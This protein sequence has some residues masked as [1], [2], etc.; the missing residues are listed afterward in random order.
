MFNSH[1]IRTIL[2]SRSLLQLGIWIRNF[3]ILL[4]ITEVTHND[5]LAVSLIS[6]AEFGPIF[7][8]AII[9]GTFADR[10]KPKL[11][12]IA[13]DLLSACSVFIVLLVLIYGTWHA[14]FY[15]TLVSSIMS[16]FSQP[17]G[18]KLF[19]QHIPEDKLQGT[20]A[21]YQTVMSLFMVIGPLIGVFAFEQYGIR[22]SLLAAGILFVG[23]A[24]ILFFLPQDEGSAEFKPSRNF[25]KE[26]AEGFRYVY[27][28][29]HLR[30]LGTTFAASGLAVGLR[31]PLMIFVA[32]ENL[33]Q[34]KEYL[35][36]LLMVNGAA[37][38]VG[39][40]MIM[41][42]AKKVRPQ[43]LL[44]FGLTMSAISTFGVGW[45]TS[46]P[47]TLLLQILSGLCYPAIMIGINTL[48]MKNTEG[49][50]MGRVGGIIT[51]MF[52]GMMVL[53]MSITGVL[54]EPL[55]LFG[56]FAGSGMLFLASSFLLIP[57]LREKAYSREM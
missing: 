9:G 27:N 20:M 22:I 49:A 21:M 14:L 56:V 26:L 4:Y 36:W 18:M 42:I 52:M 51:P 11:T 13:S 53:G 47:L 50:F 35:Q 33:G 29:R 8:F 54:K 12:M 7:L 48:V 1:F 40:I 44:A 55:T 24:F 30:T 32:I 34:S 6:V 39:G 37:V 57:L 2:L 19:K 23:S 25:K 3:A 31:Q 28:N 15:A 17:S 46:I 43:S 38:L 45:S 5:P 10:W 16:Q 41:G